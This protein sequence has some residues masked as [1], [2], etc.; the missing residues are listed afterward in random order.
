MVST[1]RTVLRTQQ[2]ADPRNLSARVSLHTRF[3]VGPMPW[4]EWVFDRLPRVESGTVLDVGCGSGLLWRHNAGRIPPAWRLVL[5]DLS[6]GMAAA[7]ALAVPRADAVV[8]DAA[9]LP[10]RDASVDVVVASH[11]L[12]HLPDVAGAIAE[13]RRV[14]RATG[15]LVAVTNGRMHLAEV[16]E[17]EH[18]ALPDLYPRVRHPELGF[19]VENGEELL[20]GSFGDVVR[21][22]FPDAL[23]VDE[24]AP[25]VDYIASM[26]PRELHDDELE[27]VATAVRRRL[28]AGPIRITKQTSMFVAQ[29]RR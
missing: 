18:D 9:T 4:F 13:Q 3:S 10:F 28:A 27:G 12:Y 2:Y 17:L 22:D 25:L 1:D 16:L 14:L 26:A 15:T 29:G 23:R 7:A 8:A 20:R 5:A 19:S 11:M 6:D 21:H 24:V